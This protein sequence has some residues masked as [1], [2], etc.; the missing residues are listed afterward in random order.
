MQF[1]GRVLNTVSEFYK[2]INP[3]TLS[4]A[5]DIVVVEDEH[6]N[7][8]CSPFHV[9]FGKLHLFRPQEKIV[10]VRVNGNVIDIPMKVGDAGETFFVLQNMVFGDCNDEGGKE[11]AGRV[12]DVSVD[13]TSGR[14]R[15]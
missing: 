2:D 12:F 6:G 10:E 3:A 5:I 11:C 9:R 7:L 8:S 13:W 15:N 4:G 14:D 1:V